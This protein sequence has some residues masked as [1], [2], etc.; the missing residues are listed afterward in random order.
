MKHIKWET[1]D[2]LQQKF[3][4]L[5]SS[6]RYVYIPVINLAYYPSEPYRSSY[7]GIGVLEEGE[8]I[9]HID[10]N[11]FHIQAPAIIF[12][13]TTSIKRW[14]KTRPSYE[15][16]SIL[17]SEDFLQ[18]KLVEN[19]VLTAFSD[20][21][22][23]GG[24]VTQLTQEEFNNFKTLFRV[25]EYANKVASPHH[26]EVI[27]G[28]VYSMVNEIAYLYEKYG[29]KTKALNTIEL[30]FRQA[31]ARYCKT[32]RSVAFYADYLHVHPKYLSQVISTETGLTASEWIHKQVILEAKILLQDN[33]LSIGII[34]EN[35]NFPDVSTFGKYFKRYEGITPKQYRNTLI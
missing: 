34:A 2:R 13:D 24:C 20:L 3:T 21:S 7:Y 1:L 18:D 9:F 10:L 22:S 33:T 30:R 12:A 6:N 5:D 35:L 31:V 29:N 14:D 4:E 23:L 8:I 25:I 27:R 19:N 15:M 32:E 28:A 11:E 17:F 26:L 16:E